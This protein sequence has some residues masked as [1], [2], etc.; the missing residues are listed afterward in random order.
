[1]K[2]NLTLE[3]AKILLNCIYGTQ[4]VA[5]TCPDMYMN[6]PE[7]PT[8]LSDEEVHNSIVKMCMQNKVNLY[9]N[10]VLTYTTDRPNYDML[11]EELYPYDGEIISIINSKKG[12]N[13]YINTL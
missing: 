4:C 6:K 10:E 3:E 5:N 2:I 13:W 7:E 8:V 1:M 12:N 9:I 11:A